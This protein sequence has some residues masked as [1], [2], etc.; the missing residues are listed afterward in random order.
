M[1]ALG[2]PADRP[3]RPLEQPDRRPFAEVV[4]RG[5]W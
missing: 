2:E 3:L 1:L 5:R 4:H